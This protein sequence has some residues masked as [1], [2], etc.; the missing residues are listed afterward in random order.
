MLIK[1]LLNGKEINL[2]GDN[3]IIKSTN[4]NVD[5]YGNMT[6][7]NATVNNLKL[8][9]EHLEVASNGLITMSVSNALNGITVNS[10]NNHLHTTISPVNIRIKNDNTGY[11]LIL[12]S[13]GLTVDG[14]TT[15]I[16]ETQIGATSMYAN[17]YYNY[18]IES[19]KKN[20]EEL[21]D[22]IKII[23]N[24]DI[25]K[26]NFKEEKN[27]D[28]KHIGFIIGNNYKYSKEIT[29]PDNN[30][31]DVYSMVSVAFKAIQEQ[32]EQIEQLQK[33]IKELKGDNNE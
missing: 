7:S 3:T 13:V 5:K 27:E 25:Y 22:A 15:Y 12:N 17:N 1:F 23:K 4:F 11:G 31:V 20:F 16:N 14:G 8:S 2:T 24:T 10:Y 29:S 28:K 26:Y 9:S 32:Q 18:S 30:G 21:T 19:K 33:E 6:C